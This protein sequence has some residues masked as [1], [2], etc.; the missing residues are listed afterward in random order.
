MSTTRQPEGGPRRPGR[1]PK[2]HAAD[3]RALL[4]DAALDAFARHGYAGTSVRAIARAA[5]LSDSGLYAHF[6]SKQDLYQALM[7]EAGPQAALT[8]SD[9]S[10]GDPP[11]H[12]RHLV[13]QTVTAWD[14][15][16]ARR[17]LSLRLREGLTAGPAGAELLDA[18][19][20]TLAQLGE[21]FAAWR[22]QGLVRTP[23]HISP[24][25]LAWQLLAPVAYVRLLHLHGSASPALRR[26]GRRLVQQH[27]DFFLAA[28][29]GTAPDGQATTTTSKPERSS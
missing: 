27:L 14:Q 17:A 3:T 20:Q 8:P 21:L 29:F 11:A 1:P 2:Q 13:D 28:V 4:L 25:Q 26:A 9:A 15:P 6:R 18:I 10:P 12:L 23:A 24:R 22:Q 7:R 16:R 19:E 5:G